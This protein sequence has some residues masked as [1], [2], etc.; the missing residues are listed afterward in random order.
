MGPKDEDLDRL[1]EYKNPRGEPRSMAWGDLMQHGVA[2][3][4]TKRPHVELGM[5]RAIQVP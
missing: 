1:V 4:T 5:L 2:D 3:L